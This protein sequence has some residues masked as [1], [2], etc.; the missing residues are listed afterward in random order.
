V[1]LPGITQQDIVHILPVIGSFTHQHAMARI[2]IPVR[3]I[4]EYLATADDSGNK[5]S[6][7][8]NAGGIRFLYG[9]VHRQYLYGLY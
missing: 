5:R 6:C 3:I 1:T 8:I 9:A 4:I 2:R 7:R